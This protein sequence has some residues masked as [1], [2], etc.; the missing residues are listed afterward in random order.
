MIPSD[1]KT[2]HVSAI[3]CRMMQLMFN[4]GKVLG[5]KWCRLAGVKVSWFARGWLAGDGRMGM[6]ELKG[7]SE[8]IKTKDQ[9]L[10]KLLEHGKF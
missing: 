9:K 2:L 3:H 7:F 6:N 1:T 4:M 8:P 10:V 5:T